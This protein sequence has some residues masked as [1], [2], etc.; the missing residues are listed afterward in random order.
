MN[1][2]LQKHTQL[3]AIWKKMG[4]NEEE[5]K[6]LLVEQG[7]FPEQIEKIIELTNELRF[8]TEEKNEEDQITNA[9]ELDRDK[10]NELIQMVKAWNLEENPSKYQ[11]RN[12]L[13]SLGVDE[14]H[15]EAI[16]TA[17]REQ[18]QSASN[19]KGNW[20]IAQGIIMTMSYYIMVPFSGNATE[21]RR[22]ISRLLLIPFFGG[23]FMIA[24]GFAKKGTK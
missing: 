1:E 16:R 24:L 8:K 6:A 18:A 5:I 4:K 12:K 21:E 7:L 3:V 10:L 13:K 22:I 20:Q 11:V 15:H 2:E 23:L 9:D 19:R 17:A 14:K